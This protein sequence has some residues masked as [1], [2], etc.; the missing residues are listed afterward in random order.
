MIKGANRETAK[1][2]SAQ[3]K[4]EKKVVRRFSIHVF[5]P[6]V[7]SQ[8]R[9]KI[10]LPNRSVDC[11]PTRHGISMFEVRQLGHAVVLLRSFL[12][13]NL[14]P[15]DVW[16]QSFVEIHRAQNGIDDRKDDQHDGDHGKTGQTL[17]HRYIVGSFAW[18]VHAGKLENEIGQ[19]SEE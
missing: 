14:A 13:A 2:R 9:I 10:S 17:A 8:A 18:L 6:T 3:K 4:E 1:H 19:S 15:H 11:H 7:F 12:P 5:C 16:L